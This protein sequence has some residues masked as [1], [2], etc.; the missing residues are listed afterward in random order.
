MTKWPPIEED[1]KHQVCRKLHAAET[2]FS[3]AAVTGKSASRLL[4]D[5]S[6][7]IPI[8]RV[9]KKTIH[10][11]F[12]HKFGKCRPIFKIPSLIDSQGNFL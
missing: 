7:P 1:D 8:R 12:D 6:L 5:A 9:S 3:V 2:A 11:T 4:I 10:L